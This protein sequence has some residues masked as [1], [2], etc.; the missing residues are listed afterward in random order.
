M[1]RRAI[2]LAL[3][4]QAIAAVGAQEII[5]GGE[6]RARASV[7]AS[8]RLQEI[9]LPQMTVVL[10]PQLAVY[11][12]VVELAVEGTIAHSLPPATAELPLYSGITEQPGTTGDYVSLPRTAL[13]ASL[14]RLELTLYPSE[15]LALHLG[16]FTYTPGRS[17]LLSPLNYFAGYELAALVQGRLGSALAPANLVQARAF[18]GPAYAT[19]TIA[20]VPSIPSL[21]SVSSV[22]FPQLPVD[23]EISIPELSD[24]PLRLEDLFSV[25]TDAISGAYRRISA[26]AELGITLGALDATLSYFH[27]IDPIPV[28]RA[29]VDIP[30]STPSTF[31]LIV[32]P[33]EAIIDSIGL[34]AEAAIGSAT[35]WM[36]TAFDLNRT[37]P[38]TRIS[39]SSKRNVLIQVPTVTGVIGTSY[40][41][42]PP[43]LLLLAEFRQSVAF[44]DETEIL[45]L[46]LSSIGVVTAR[47]ADA[48]NRR[49]L[50]LGA[51]V[52]TSDVAAINGA[53]FSSA[54]FTPSAELSVIAQAPIFWGAEAGTF[55]T[56]R[57][58]YGGSIAIIYRF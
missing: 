47:L 36:D 29:K 27:G 52:D 16:R 19:A 35:V 45:D 9:V 17:L 55:G 41:F 11:G 5:F 54:E 31:D 49:I 14:D 56:Y 10:S 12:S 7:L 21:P 20:P 46:G 39:P 25:P 2:A 23:D 48:D 13:S 18:F 3:C 1:A 22:W 42:Y 4:V 15:W 44:T 34:S 53:V 8:P 38:T 33:E 50:S 37:L 28:L 58:V 26:E 43:N 32:A 24:E 40:Q 30:E 51:L 6:A 57:D